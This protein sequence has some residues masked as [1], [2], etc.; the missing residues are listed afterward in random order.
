I[1]ANT[2]TSIGKAGKG[3]FL[4]LTRQIIF[5][6]PLLIILPLVMGIE[7]VMFSAPIADGVAAVLCV[8]FIVK[9]FKHMGTNS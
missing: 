6:L 2:F 1:T 3:V 5:L 8:F 9:E 7:G 4:S